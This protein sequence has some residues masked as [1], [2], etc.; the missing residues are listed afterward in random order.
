M[1]RGVPIRAVCRAISILQEINQ[2]GSLSMMQI[3]KRGR[4]PYPTACRIVQ[5]LMHEGLVEQEPA[6][7]FY[8]PTA[9]VQSLSQGF[10][11]DSLLVE[12]SRPHIKALTEKIGWPVSLTV[13]IGTHMVVRDSTHANTSLTFERYYPGFRLPLMDCASGRVCLAHMTAEQLD[14]VMDWVSLVGSPGEQ[15][16]T[17]YVSVN[18]LN[19]IR[20]EGYAAIGWGQH[21]LT[22][23][24]TS[25]LAVPIFRDGKFEAALTMIYFAAAMKQG[26]A[27]ERHLPDLKATAAAITEEIN[28][29]DFAVHMPALVN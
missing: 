11:T 1:E 28:R 15:E 8:R 27:V 13:R 9:L 2:M 26:E 7:K 14:K 16:Q 17:A 6:R 18:T 4:I 25:S 5:T 12:Q 22:P 20:D 24:K 10:Q 3:A 21:N 23:G 29:T 19:K